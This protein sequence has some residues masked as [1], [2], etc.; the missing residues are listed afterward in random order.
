MLTIGEF[1]RVCKVSTKTLRYYAEI[2]LILPSK[3]NPENNYR[4]YTIEQLDTML[5]IN[6][7]KSYQFSLEEIKEI[8]D[9]RELIDEKIYEGLLK[10]KD[11][12]EHQVNH[13]EKTMNQIEQ[14][15]TNLS[16]GKSMM[17]YLDEIQ[18]ELVEVEK[19]CILSIRKM[20]PQLEIPRQY[21]LCFQQL[22]D[23]IKQENIQCETY[24]IVL[25]HD[26]TF[27]EN[28]LDIEF[29][30]IINNL[31]LDKCW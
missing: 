14:D 18:I 12:M 16:Q 13:I 19:M 20:I 27:R 2:G 10:K 4:Y 1:S 31:T 5:L 8:M 28:G 29:A 11:N 9:S 30:F 15:L 23:R 25:F 17:S 24:P 26:D 6:R 21:T 7:L 22:L 3:I